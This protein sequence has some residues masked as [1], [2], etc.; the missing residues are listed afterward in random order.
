VL[1]RGGKQEF[2]PERLEHF[3]M[4]ARIQTDL[5]RFAIVE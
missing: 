1:A 2:I 5:A 4:Q 3:A